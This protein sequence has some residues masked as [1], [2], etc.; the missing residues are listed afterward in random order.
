MTADTGGI[1]KKNSRQFGKNW[2]V[3]CFIASRVD[4]ISCKVVCL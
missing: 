3:L 4:K 1:N 2:R